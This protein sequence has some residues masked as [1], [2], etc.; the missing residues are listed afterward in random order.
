VYKRLIWLDES[1]EQREGHHFHGTYQVMA[2][3]DRAMVLFNDIRD[4]IRAKNSICA[5]VEDYQA[6]FVESHSVSGVSIIGSRTVYMR[7]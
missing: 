2:A 3:A 1:V 5:T 7:G 6:D 4:S